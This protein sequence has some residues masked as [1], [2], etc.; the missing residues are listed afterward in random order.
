M[1]NVFAKE[2]VLFVPVPKVAAEL[3]ADMTWAESR[4]YMCLLLF[5][6]VH[7]AAELHIPTRVISDYTKLHAETILIARK[8][9]EKRGYIHCSR[10]FQGVTTYHV[11]NP[12]NGK[13]LAPQKIGSQQFSGVF[14][15][16]AK[17]AGGVSER[18]RREAQRSIR[19]VRQANHR[20]MSP[21]RDEIWPEDAGPKVTDLTGS[22]P[23]QSVSTTKQIRKDLSDRLG[24]LFLDDVEKAKVN[25]VPNSRSEKPSEEKDLKGNMKGQGTS[26]TAA[27]TEERGSEIAAALAENSGARRLAEMFGAK[28]VGVVDH[29]TG[30]TAGDGGQLPGLSYAEWMDQQIW[31]KRRPRFA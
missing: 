28:V 11:L 12:L 24:F 2:G 13:E 8:G 20:S 4:L 15:Y 21:S 16:D 3:W 19:Q 9:L 18:S 17:S 10:G 29:K 31:G 1:S 6:H 5:A 23:S 14:K 27:M 26:S 7:T 30:A 22:K 25:D